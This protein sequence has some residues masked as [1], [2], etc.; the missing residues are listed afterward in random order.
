MSRAP[1]TRWYVDWHDAVAASGSLSTSTRWVAQVLARHADNGTG[2]VTLRRKGLSQLATIA[3]V[4]SVGER[5]VSRAFEQLEAAQ[6]VARK[7]R[8]SYFDVYLLDACEA[9]DGPRQNG[10]AT[11]SQNGGQPR[12]D[13][14][15][16][17]RSGDHVCSEVFSDVCSPP[18]P[19]AR[20]S[21]READQSSPTTLAEWDERF[22]GRLRGPH[23]GVGRLR[24]P[25]PP[26]RAYSRLVKRDGHVPEKYSSQEWEALLECASLLSDRW[27]IVD[28]AWLLLAEWRARGA[29]GS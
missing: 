26:E 20:A 1:M 25:L 15:Q 13:G 29:G 2:K 8:G 6:L 28:R 12:Q 27:D 4:A 5:T 7:W 18:A 19:L 24:Y 14:G 21:A 16:P 17:C 9:D 22:R 3:A 23:R 11:C 10:E